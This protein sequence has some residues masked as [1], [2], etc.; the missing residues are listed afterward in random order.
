MTRKNEK[1]LKKIWKLR[2]KG[3]ELYRDG[4]REEALKLWT[5]ATELE[6]ESVIIRLSD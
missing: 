4:K 5:K 3:Y 6:E 2:L 1:K